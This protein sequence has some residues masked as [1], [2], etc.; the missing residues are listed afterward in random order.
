M[1]LSLR[2]VHFL[3]GPRRSFNVSLSCVEPLKSVGQN[4][5]RQTTRFGRSEGQR[6]LAVCLAWL[7]QATA[8][9]RTIEVLRAVQD[10]MAAVFHLL[11]IP[12]VT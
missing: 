12:I 1:L 11:L 4:V 10:E 7:P 5:W 3:P 2:P 9:A 6:G 8:L